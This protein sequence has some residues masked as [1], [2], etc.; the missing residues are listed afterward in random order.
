MRK[1]RYAAAALAVMGTLLAGAPFF[2]APPV[3][4]M[5]AEAAKEQWVW[6]S[7]DQKYGKFFS[8]SNVQIKSKVNGVA[9]CISAWIKTA[10]T[11]GGAQE[12]I[13]NYGIQASIPDPRTLSYSLALVEVI[14]QER[15][16]SYI[17]EN[18]YNADGKVIWSTVYE[19]QK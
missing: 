2:D 14:P 1:M 3:G 15:K 8:P 5:R 4:T 6:I 18:F 7:S 10:Y 9:T 12:A 16:I 17:Q 11:P 19:P 13:E